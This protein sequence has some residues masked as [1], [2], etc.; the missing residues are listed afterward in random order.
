MALKDEVFKPDVGLTFHG[1]HTHFRVWAPNA[2]SVSLSGDFNNWEEIPLKSEEDGYW[3]I[4]EENVEPGTTYKYVIYTHD[5]E[6]LYR[7]DPRGL[8]LTDSS[9]GVS[10]VPDIDFDWED[11]AFSAS[12]KENTIIYEMHVGTFSRVDKATNG[13]F[14]DAI[15]KLDYLK[16]LGITTIEL[17]PIT[18]MSQGFGWGYAPNNLYSVENSYGGRRGFMEFV[19]ECHKRQIG[20]ILDV[21][22]NHFDGDYL[23]RFDGWSENDSGGIYFYNDDRSKTP[24]GLRPDYGRP[25]VRQYILDNIKM[26]LVDYHV[27]GVRLDSTIFMRNRNGYNNDPGGDLPD[28]WS[29]LGSITE[30]AHSINENALVVCEDCSGNDYLTKPVD[31]GGC[32]FDAQWDLSLPHS[33]RGALARD[34]GS[35]DN[36]CY[37]LFLNFNG[38]Y[39]EK[40]I[41]ADSHDT[42][43][44]GSDRLT[45][46][47]KFGKENSP[48]AQKISILASAVALTAPGIPMILQGQEFMQGGDFNNWVE[49]EW[50]KAERFSGVVLANQHLINLRLNKYGNTAGLVGGSVDI[51]HRNDDNSVLGYRRTDGK[52]SEVLVLI[53][54][55]KTTIE[56]YNMVLPSKEPWNVDFNSSWK[57]YGES[58]AE[59]DLEILEP[60]EQGSVSLDLMGYMVLIL[61]KANK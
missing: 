37:S 17:M 41:F 2:K 49:L 57:G 40:V 3:H 38:N 46:L 33:L 11:D 50:E 7:N 42:A 24:W 26:W 10:V 60:D 54:F 43:A 18:S 34:F 25:E 16:Q 27:D 32:G 31:S 20:V 23:W 6:K 13:T 29:L 61:S 59:T 47:T 56:G 58:F 4:S 15:E 35:L 44:N 22:Y 19:K 51:F 30:L 28:A 8:Q 9:E 1:K 55:S 48:T 5:D 39:L 21:V 14:Y 45:D 52:G 12:T 53:N 36:L